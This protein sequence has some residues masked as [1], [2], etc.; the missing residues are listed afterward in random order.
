VPIRDEAIGDF[1]DRLAAQR[2]SPGGTAAAALLAAQA[3]ALLGMAARFTAAGGQPRPQVAAGRIA[4]EVDELRDIGLRLA[5]AEAEA[6]AAVAAATALPAGTSQERAGRDAAIA[7]AVTSAA[8]PATQ[9][10]SVAGM[11]VDLAEALA[12]LAV[13]GTGCDI[14]AAAEVARAAAATA[15]VALEASLADISDDEASLAMIAATG[16]AEGIIARAGQVTEA[17]RDRIRAT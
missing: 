3:A 15:R 6:F 5:E 17:V 12:P 4:T 14:A 9:V 1:L 11:V 13:P 2:P 16:D 7:R 10:I 8:W